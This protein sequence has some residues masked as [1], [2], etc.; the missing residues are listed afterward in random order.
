MVELR[1]TDGDDVIRTGEGDDVVRAGAGDDTIHY[2][3]DEDVY[4][5][6][7]GIDTV[8]IEQPFDPDQI[9]DHHDFIPRTSEYLR[10]RIQFPHIQKETGDPILPFGYLYD[11]GMAHHDPA[12]L[13]PSC[14]EG[15][16]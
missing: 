9:W 14:F 2:E 10:A 7:P 15:S 13:M 1:G 6:G 8:V 4:Y 11:V 12:T 3:R 16:S 5:G